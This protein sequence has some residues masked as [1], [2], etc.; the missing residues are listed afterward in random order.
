M[1]DRQVTDRPVMHWVPVVD[2]R[3]R[4]HLEARWSLETTSTAPAS[5]PHAA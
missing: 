5:K 3:G 1:R 2:D 4:T